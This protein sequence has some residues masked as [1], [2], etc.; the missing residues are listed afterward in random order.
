MWSHL[1]LRRLFLCLAMMRVDLWGQK[2][3]ATMV[4]DGPIADPKHVGD[5]LDSAARVFRAGSQC[6]RGVWS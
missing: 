4:G 1:L 6:V 2:K 5:M 3:F